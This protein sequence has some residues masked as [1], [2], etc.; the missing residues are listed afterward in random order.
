MAGRASFRL[1]GSSNVWRQIYR[2]YDHES[3]AVFDSNLNVLFYSVGAVFPE[4]LTVDT[5]VDGYMTI[6]TRTI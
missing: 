5:E 3:I 1:A 6:L 2:P 4:R